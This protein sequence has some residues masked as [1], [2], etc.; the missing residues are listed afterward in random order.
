MSKVFKLQLEKI[1]VVDAFIIKLFET[2][3]NNVVVTNLHSDKLEDTYLEAIKLALDK[4]KKKAELMA[5]HLN[6]SIGQVI[7]ISEYKP[8]I[9]ALEKNEAFYLQSKTVSAY[10]IDRMIS[11]DGENVGIRNIKVRYIVDVKYEIK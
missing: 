6:S 8:Q 2:G 9:Q 11:S 3:A 1:E 5:S 7:E 10:G 4:A